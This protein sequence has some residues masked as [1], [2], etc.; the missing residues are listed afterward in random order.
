[1]KKTL[2]VILSFTMLILTISCKDKN[3]KTETSIINIT[4][5]STEILPTTSDT[6]GTG[7]HGNY[8]N[9]IIYVESDIDDGKCVYGMHI[10]TLEVVEIPSRVEGKNVVEIAD[11]A[12]VNLANINTII[13][14]NTIKKIGSNV[15]KGCINLSNISIPTSVLSIGESTFDGCDSLL[16]ITYEGTIEE[17]NM[18]E[19]DGFNK[20]SS[21]QKVICT[22]GYID[23][24]S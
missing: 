14:P 7:T 23:L 22:D 20:N 13:I 16:E 4:T 6:S 24:I 9:R 21:I 17:F 8:Y 11:I 12:F 5:S 2:L 1:M 3:I 10:C 18:I 19:K 15:F